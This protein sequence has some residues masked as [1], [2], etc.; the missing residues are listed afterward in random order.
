MKDKI[1]WIERM[2]EAVEKYQWSHDDNETEVTFLSGSL[3]VCAKNFKIQNLEEDMLSVYYDI[4][5]VD[6]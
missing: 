4:I 3:L 6:I 2:K 5:A 1:V